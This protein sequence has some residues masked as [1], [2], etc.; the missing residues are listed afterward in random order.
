MRIKLLFATCAFLQLSSFVHA[1]EVTTQMEHGRDLYFRNC[2]ICHQLNGQGVP[3]T[4]PPLAKS[5]YLMADRE[6]SIRLLCEGL[7][8]DIVVNGKKFGGSMPP[9]VLDDAEVADVLTFVRNSWDNSDAP[10]TA[11]EVKSARAKTQ[12]PTF[13]KMLEASTYQPLPPAPK[14]CTLREVVR[15]TSHGVRMA[16]DGTGR[17]IYVLIENGDVWRLEP[18]SGAFRQIIWA[19]N[20]LDRKPGDTAAPLF[21][22]GLALSK[23]GR[24]YIASNQPNNLKP[25]YQ[26]RVTIYRTTTTQDGDPADP[27]MWFEKSYPGNS[28]YVHGMEHI[29]FGPDGML[30]AGN[31]ARTD[32]NQTNPDANYYQG[33]EMELTSSIWRLD[34]KSENPEIEIFARGVRNAYGFCWNDKGEMFATE[35]G[36]DA[37]A[38]EELNLIEKGKHYGFPYRFGDWTKKAYE[39]TPEAPAGLE[40]TLP[41]ANLGPDGGYDGKPIYSFDPHSGPGGIVFL[42]D[43]FPP[44]WRGS[45]ILNRFGNF[46]R[47]PKDNVG[48]DILQTKLEKD[49]KGVYQAHIFTV[50][51]PLGRPIDVHHS[52]RGKLYICEYSR[53]TNNQGS[54]ALPG[55]ILELSFDGDPSGS[56]K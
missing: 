50:L 37:D 48:F 23:D 7:T 15:M 21:V 20:Y 27:K 56:S 5:D 35:N 24:L 11:A 49:A 43:D 9:V 1:A 55:R 13:A 34:P 52:G 29:A 14:G 12:I 30:Y 19:K 28:A 46:I 26:N 44:Q 33:G 36:P 10:F 32:A 51:K 45:F 47:T 39:H 38:P 31:G 54:F 16:S 6:R 41:I 18:E 22:L 3:G 2:L 40:F 8:G 42:G 53:P 4:Y 25:P 17:V